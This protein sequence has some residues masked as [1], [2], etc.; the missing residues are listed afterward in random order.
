MNDDFIFSLINGRDVSKILEGNMSSVYELIK[1]TY[2]LHQKNETVNPKSHFLKFPKKPQS[3]IIALPAYI[4]KDLNIAGIKW[5]ASNP[6]NVEKGFP[7]ASAVL[8][9]ND[10]E[11]G[12]PFACI[13]ASIIS[14]VRTAASAVLG[15]EYLLGN[16]KKIKK[17]G[18]IGNG[19]ISKHILNCF[20]KTNW[21]IKEV[22]LFDKS[23]DNSLKFSEEIKKNHNIE[24]T[25]VN[26]NDELISQCEII[27]FTTTSQEPYVKDLKLFQHNPVVLNISLR[28]LDPQIILNSN[29]VVDDINHILDANT[30]VHL[31]QQKVGHSN[32]INGTIGELIEKKYVVLDKNKP[33][34]YS[35]M[36]LGILDIALG[37]YIFDKSALCKEKISISNFFPID[38]KMGEKN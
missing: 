20:L 1:K 14:A 31:A 29:N 15:A 8:I 16:I 33:S 11:T 6:K 25:L 26:S 36:G 35:P 24:V 9:L 13:E 17:I 34:I 2:L 23:Q 27:V 21:K 18:F 38:V 28:D 5:I 22:L 12:Y 7:R 4:G 30:S 37:K 19:V 10:Y 3:R 32:F